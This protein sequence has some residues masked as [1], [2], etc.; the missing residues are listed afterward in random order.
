[1]LVC[2]LLQIY[3][4]KK[5]YKL[6][7]KKYILNWASTD[8]ILHENYIHVECGSRSIIEVQKPVIILFDYILT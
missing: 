3:S 4:G 8:V 2:F 7:P 5:C 6:K 1:M